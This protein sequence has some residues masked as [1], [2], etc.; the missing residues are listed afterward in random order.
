MRLKKQYGNFDH[1]YVTI[2]DL[3]FRKS[4]MHTIFRQY[5]HLGTKHLAKLCGFNTENQWDYIKNDCSI[6]KSFEFLERLCDSLHLALLTGV[7]TG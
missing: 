1:Y 7:E 4:L 3:H 6:H 5:E 2:P